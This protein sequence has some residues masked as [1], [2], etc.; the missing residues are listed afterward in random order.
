M[1]GTPAYMAPEQ[2]VGAVE[3]VDERS[4][5]FGLGAVLAVILTGRPPFVGD[6][7]ESTRVLAARGKVED[8]FARLDACGAEPELVALCKRCLSPEREDR[9]A[10]AGA[11]ASAVAAFRA[12]AEERARQ[13][14][15][16]RVR[17]EGERA[18]LEAEAR[19]QRQKRRT[20]LAVAVGV[21]GLLVVGGGAW[22]TVRNQAEARR[23]RRR[24]PGERRAGPRRAARGPG[25]G[26]RRRRSCPRPTRPSSSGSRPRPPSPRPRVRS[27][28][29]AAPA[30]RARVREKAASGPLG[31]GQ[32]SPRRHAAGRPGGRR[33]RGRR[34][35][36]RVD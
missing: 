27:P 35:G 6:T 21:F 30:C 29:S 16:D 23:D 33:G 32:G 17:A 1:L 11:V 34:H 28:G 3:Q 9:P 4:D 19:A 5:V 2:A 15:L 26:D 36:W 22:L 12:E 25:R 31:S 14:E 7:A 8:C 24:P 20:Q 13:A 18:R 10:D